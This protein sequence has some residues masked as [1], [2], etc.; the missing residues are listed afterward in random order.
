MTATQ[1]I[2]QS[3]ETL[4]RRFDGDPDL[5]KGADS[6]A[7]ATVE[8]LR[9]SAI[10]SHDVTMISDMPEDYG[11]SDTA[12]SPGWFFRAAIASCEAMVIVMRAEALGV[13]LDH[14]EV[15]VGSESDARGLL[16]TD[17]EIPAGPLGAGISVA[18]GSQEASAG[19]LREIVRW[20]TEHSPLTDALER[21]IPTSLEIEV[22]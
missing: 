2:Q 13:A 7:T 14:L 22:S 12:P 6:R 18:I 16:G 3:M 21:A 4:A 1:D 8:G 17:A 5:A 15:T 20:S 19:D 9:A 10:G 11:G